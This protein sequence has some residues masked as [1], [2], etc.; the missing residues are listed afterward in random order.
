MQDVAK[1]TVKLD[2]RAL[3]SQA[4]ACMSRCLCLGDDWNCKVA[5]GGE[6]CLAIVE[7]T[8]TGGKLPELKKS[9]QLGSGGKRTQLVK[10][11]D[12]KWHPK[13]PEQI[14]TASSS[15]LVV[16][17]NV[18]KCSPTT[19]RRTDEAP[20]HQEHTRLVK[21]VCWHPTQ[22]AILLSASEDSTVK[23]W[24]LRTYK[25]RSPVTFRI[26]SGGAAPQ[27][28]DV[29]VDPFD[30]N[31]F[32]CS[33]DEGAELLY[34]DMRMHERGPTRRITA[35]TESSGNGVIYSVNWH[36]TRRG[37]LAV[38]SKDRTVKVWNIHSDKPDSTLTPEITIQTL[39]SVGRVH[40]RPTQSSTHTHQIAEVS[41]SP[42]DVDLNIWDYNSPLLPLCCIP[43]P[44]GEVIT[45]LEW[46]DRNGE[47]IFSTSK[48][49]SFA[50]S[51]V[52]K[53]HVHAAHL[54]TSAVAWGPNDMLA[55]HCDPV[56]FP[57]AGRHKGPLL[58]NGSPA[59]SAASEATTQPMMGIRAVSPPPAPPPPPIIQVH[60][61]KKPGFFDR[62]FGSN[63][64]RSQSLVVVNEPTTP[65]KRVA[66]QPYAAVPYSVSEGGGYLYCAD[67]PA[68]GDTFKK[69]AAGY[70]LTGLPPADLCSYNADV[71]Q[72]VSEELKAVWLVARQLVEL[73]PFR[74]SPKLVAEPVTPAS[75]MTLENSGSDE[76]TESEETDGLE[77]EG[78]CCGGAEHLGIDLSV[79]DMLVA[80]VDQLLETGDVQTVA[81]LISC[82]AATDDTH[83]FDAVKHARRGC[84][85]FMSYYELLVSSELLTTAAELMKHCPFPR[86]ASISHAGTSVE[87]KC[88]V[89]GNPLS[90]NNWQLASKSKDTLQL[91]G[92]C[93]HKAQM[94]C[95]CRFPVK[96]LYVWSRTCSHG[97]HLR[98]LKS[99]MATSKGCPHP[100]CGRELGF[101]FSE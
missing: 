44:H 30:N 57:E 10:V 101:S 98:C 55:F 9:A 23:L 1:S 22:E 65:V 45:D 5:V 43:A 59:I 8:R 70:K 68:S 62:M 63:R 75:P 96:G 26:G 24:D 35:S 34:W 21:R 77:L 46:W 48:S 36:P 47:I 25:E 7:V 28:R 51:L 60:E 19:L 50:A 66:Q 49:G 52:K 56:H 6:K 78:V 69:L 67:T 12:V 86:V 88:R 3:K 4:L 13:R 100:D 40:W 33:T 29:E 54:C 76:R 74:E 95:V 91:Q 82:V 32:L 97:G 38:G 83:P 81:T 42:L 61:A 20:T 85:W 27:I 87:A 80:L 64:K 72:G 16:V 2:S 58:P 99:W 14:A 84:E 90:Q 11:T 31:A 73:K 89:C 37:Y 17:W 71:A 93:C 39:A 41:M 15:G 18:D 94:C 92:S 79:S 53:A